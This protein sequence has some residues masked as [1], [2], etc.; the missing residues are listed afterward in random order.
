M[1]VRK[2]NYFETREIE[3]SGICLKFISYR[4]LFTIDN[5]RM[6][7]DEWF[8]DKTLFGSEIKT[9]EVCVGKSLSWE[10]LSELFPEAIFTEPIT[11]EFVMKFDGLTFVRLN[12]DKLLGENEF[13][14]ESCDENGYWLLDVKTGKHLSSSLL[15]AKPK[16]RTN[17][18]LP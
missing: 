17:T 10:K 18:Y 12:D 6:K 2:I 3:L 14:I 16:S 5:L 15:K 9:T 1:N 7:N 8:I 13:L 4:K 11:D